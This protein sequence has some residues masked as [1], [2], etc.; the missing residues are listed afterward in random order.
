MAVEQAHFRKAGNFALAGTQNLAT[1]YPQLICS[2]AGRNCC[3]LSQ[4]S[5]RQ[6]PA[7]STHLIDFSQQKSASKTHFFAF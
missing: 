6:L 4:F 5:T 2:Q 7:K 1:S 3:L